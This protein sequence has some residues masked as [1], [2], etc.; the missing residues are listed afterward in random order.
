MT[1]TI[2]RRLVRTI[3]V[4]TIVLATTIAGT[5]PAF[6]A[7]PSPST[8][9]VRVAH[10]SPDTRPVDVR[11]T[12]VRHRTA[13]FQLDRVA[14]GAISPYMSLTPG[15]YVVTMTKAGSSA[16]STPVARLTVTVAAG[17]S[18]TVAAYGRDVSLRIKA[19]AD[20]LTT[21]PPG[22][23]R[24]R[25]LQASTLTPVVTVATTSG[26]TIAEKAPAGRATP[27]V[28]VPAG[29]WTLR[30]G[31]KKLEFTSTVSLVPGSVT[32]LVV[33]DTAAGG[34]TARPVVDSAAAAQVPVGAVQTGGGFLAGNPDRTP[35]GVR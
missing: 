16:T 33:I 29:P 2:T 14:Y 12:A 24:I 30:L 17:S 18:S 15:R 21:P 34:L 10:L 3:V 31:G 19:F 22:I 11:L 13:V 9:W 32:T 23:A 4:S 7:D 8:G 25:L 26:K 27:Y 20:D 6:A 5:A 35:A 1:Q 28:D